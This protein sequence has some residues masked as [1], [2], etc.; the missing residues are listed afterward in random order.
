MAWGDVIFDTDSMIRKVQHSQKQ[1]TTE[2]ANEVVRKMSLG[3]RAAK[4]ISK[5][6]EKFR[7]DSSDGLEVEETALDTWLVK[8]NGAAGTLYEGES[9]TLRI[10]FTS[11]YPIDSPAVTFLQPAPAHPHVYSNGHICLNILGEDWS[12]ALTAK[13]VC[14]SILSMLSSAEIKE[15]PPDDASYSARKSADSNPKS[16]RFAY[17]D[18]KV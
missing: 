5:E 9:F 6:L 7:Q 1:K 12:P 3:A 16:T 10:K 4:R 2:K 8:F 17:H 11:E 18:D 15:R 14:L 13:S